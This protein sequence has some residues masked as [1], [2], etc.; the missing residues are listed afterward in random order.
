MISAVKYL[1]DALSD[2]QILTR[3]ALGGSVLRPVTRE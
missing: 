2:S 3:L 1:N